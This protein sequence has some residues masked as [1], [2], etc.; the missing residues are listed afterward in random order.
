MKAYKAQ[1]CVV[2]EADPAT[3]QQDNHTHTHP[4]TH[5]HTNIYTHTHT[6][7][8]AHTHACMHTHTHTHTRIFIQWNLAG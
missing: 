8:H 4:Q 1:A 5:T 6:S 7:M 3:P 2:L